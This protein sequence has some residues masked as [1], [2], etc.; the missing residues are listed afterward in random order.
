MRVVTIVEIDIPF[1]ALTYGVAPC[2]AAL[3][4]TGSKKCFNTRRTCQDLANFD[5]ETLTV[6]FIE[7]SADL[8]YEA[9]P[10]LVDVDTT[11][12]RIDPGRSL[13]ER[14]SVTVSFSDHPH[15][16]AGPVLFDKY[17]ADRSYVPFEQGTFWGK[18]RA[19]HTSLKGAALRIR[20]GELGDALED[21]TV[22]H[23]VIESMSG[24]ANSRFSITA[25]DELKLADGDRSKAPAISTGFLATAIDESETSVDIAPASAADDYPASGK[26]AIGGKEICTFTRSGAT[27][28]IGRGE[29]NTEAQTHDAD[30]RV[31][32]VLEYDAETAADIIYDLLTT[33]T[34][35]P[36]SSIPLADWQTEVDAN[37]GRLYS[38]EIAQPTSVRKLVDELI[39]QV[40]LV[41][42]TDV[43]AQEIRLT[44]LRAVTTTGTVYGVDRIVRGSYSAKEQPKKRI[45]QAWTYYGQRNPLA[46]LDDE[47]NYEFAAA[48]IDPDGTEVDYDDQ[49]A[50]HEVFS[51]WI[52][53]TNRPAAESLNDLLLARYA[54]PPRRFTFDIWASDTLPK[55]GLGYEI[56]HF[57]LQTDEGADAVAGVQIVS[58]DTE[59]DRAKYAA[60]ETTFGAS[61]GNDRAVFIDSDVYELNLRDLYDELYTAPSNYT[62]I[63]FVIPA[64]VQV[65]GRTCI[66][67]LGNGHLFL[68]EQ[69]AALQVGDWPEGPTL[70]L[71]NNGTIAGG[72]ANGQDARFDSSDGSQGKTAIWARYPIS[73][74]NNGLIGG[75][76]GG[77]GR[78]SNHGGGGGAGAIREYPNSYG[79]NDVA[80]TGGPNAD[81]TTG[82]DSH[83]DAGLLETGGAAGGATGGAGGDLGQAGTDGSGASQPAAGDAGRAVDGDSYVT[84]SPEGDVRGPR[85]N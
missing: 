54:D 18:F 14:E 53:G 1:C 24:P 41:M 3:G 11:P 82:S 74:E 23:Y 80:S 42:W 9:L 66:A 47:Q 17:I 32:L 51:R 22:Y 39:E 21:M 27:L 71:I 83:A 70:V 77:G 63:T 84:F 16:D 59:A 10:N 26:V 85:I 75:G 28:T 38:A 61:T 69:Y 8:Q 64:G 4:S 44:A 12:Q 7:A 35:V 40:G 46:D 65:G 78:G 31:Q 76:G 30:E 34:N 79:E 58:V 55:L 20:R 60:E 29:S 57:D 56:S 15:S 43:R 25:K 37:I 33:Y 36:A 68:A 19:R 6:R 45:S 49:P 13:G 50:I 5:P 73:I 67:G 72:G 52:L 62:T 81:W 2:E 48:A